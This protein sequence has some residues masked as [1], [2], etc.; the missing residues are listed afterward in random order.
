MR[1][2]L[3]RRSPFRERASR[4]LA[5][6]MAAERRKREETN[7]HREIF[8]LGPLGRLELMLVSACQ[9][10]AYWYANPHDVQFAACTTINTLSVPAREENEFAAHE[11]LA[12]MLARIEAARAA[13]LA[14]T[15]T[16]P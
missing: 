9:W 5:E 1:L 10:S 12:W 7:V 13:I 11:A 2:H 14:H 8:D 3:G 6:T 4:K 15:G 16:T